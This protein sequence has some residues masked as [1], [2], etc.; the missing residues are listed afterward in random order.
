MGKTK[1]SKPPSAMK[2]GKGESST[3]WYVCA[4]AVLLVA[5]AV[6]F[7]WSRPPLP[8]REPATKPIPKETSTKAP[9]KQ[10]APPRTQK[11]PP[12]E[13]ASKRVDQM[14]ECV[15]WAEL[16]EC[17]KNPDFMRNS[18]QASCPHLEIAEVPASAQSDAKAAKASKKMTKDVAWPKPELP[19]DLAQAQ[20]ETDRAGVTTLG[21]GC[22]DARSDCETL[23]RWNLSACGEAPFMLTECSRTCGTCHY[24]KLISQVTEACKDSHDQCANWASMGEC[25]NN[26]RFMLN[27]C[28][29]SCGVCEEK[30]VGCSR[31]NVVPGVMP[32]TGMGE[33]FR[34]ALTDPETLARYET[35]ALSTDPYVLQ[36]EN[37]LDE[38]EARDMI[39]R[40]A[41]D[42]RFERSMAGDQLSPVRTSTQCW[43]DDT[44]GCIDH[45]TVT[46]ITERMMNITRLPVEN[47]EYFQILKYEP[48][49]FYKVLAPYGALL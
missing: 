32:P 18:C 19:P 42:D 24:G 36:F 11:A 1:A 16:G 3:W 33:M 22:T 34:H 43:C 7:G 27:G 23:A 15:Q 45:P 48:G 47:A 5:V 21:H 40:C 46:K 26:K 4:A 30:K 31:R 39:S 29:V 20:L 37:I 17:D 41:T 12:R 9:P 13:E 25:E 44:H 38:S 8:P 2:K 14:P 35:K 10:K 28:S 49:Q 6:A